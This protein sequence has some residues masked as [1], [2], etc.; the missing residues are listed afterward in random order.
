[1]EGCDLE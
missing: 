1:M